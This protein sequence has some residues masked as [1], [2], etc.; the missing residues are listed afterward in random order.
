[1]S[2]S[3]AVSR[4]QSRLSEGCSLESTA[5]LAKVDI[6]VVE[7]LNKVIGKHGYAFH[8]A[9]VQNVEVEALQADE[10]HDFSETKGKRRGKP[11]V[12]DPKTDD[13]GA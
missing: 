7:R 12:I 3:R 13:S 2:E 9:H 11:E 1:M 10:R 4:W 8:G 5:R 6:S